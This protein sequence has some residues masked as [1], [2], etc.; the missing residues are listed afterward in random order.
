MILSQRL[1]NVQ[2]FQRLSH[3]NMLS[4]MVSNFKKLEYLVLEDLMLFYLVFKQ[5]F[6]EEAFTNV[7]TKTI[8]HFAVKYFQRS[9]HSFFLWHDLSTCL[10]NCTQW[11]YKCLVTCVKTSEAVKILFSDKVLFWIIFAVFLYVSLTEL[12]DAVHASTC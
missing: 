5:N 2:D 12:I 11:N 7:E 9:N 10:N 1:K 8:P 6:Y 4:W 3:N